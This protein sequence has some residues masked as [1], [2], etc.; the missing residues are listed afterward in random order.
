[1]GHKD[2]KLKDR[3]FIYRAKTLDEISF[4]ADRIQLPSGKEYDYVYVDCPYEVV[5]VVGIDKD[6][7]VLLI[8]QYRYLLN[9]EVIEIP[10]GSPNPG[11]TLEQGAKREFEEES[12]FTPGRL[13]KL[14]TFYPS[15]GMTNQKGHIYLALDLKQ[16]QQTLEDGEEIRIEWVPLSDVLKMISE[17][18]IKNGGAA[19]GLLLA[20]NWQTNHRK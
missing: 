5:Y 18:L 11:E 13:I 8:H 20:A 1:M 9:E 3:T 15:S 16:S 19:Y 10:A 7:N 14:T 12:G 6:D 4:V 2:W 17:G